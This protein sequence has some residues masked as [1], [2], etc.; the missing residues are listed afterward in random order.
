MLEASMLVMPRPLPYTRTAATLPAGIERSPWTDRLSQT[1]T[2]R[3]FP[4]FAP[5][6]KMSRWGLYPP[7]SR[8]APTRPA[9]VP[10]HVVVGYA[11][12][13]NVLPRSVLMKEGM[14]LP[15]ICFGHKN[16]K[17]TEVA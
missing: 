12:S 9:F 15:K 8:L 16:K 6:P 10:Y 13:T 1:R 17:L 2:L 4:E 11:K 14:I 3:R 7:P 5:I